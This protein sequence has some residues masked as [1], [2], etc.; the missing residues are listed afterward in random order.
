LSKDEKPQPLKIEILDRLTTLITAAFGFVAAFAWNE[1]F[2]LLLDRVVS[3][4]AELIVYFIYAI[5]ITIVAVLLIISVARATA[6][7]KSKLQ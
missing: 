4:D 7:A 1:T 2:K 3:E 5:I 6:K